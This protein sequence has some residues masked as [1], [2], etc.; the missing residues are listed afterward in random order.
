MEK[1]ALEEHVAEW[2]NRAGDGLDDLP[3]EKGRVVLRLLLDGGDHR[4]GEQGQ[5][6]AGSPRG[7]VVSIGSPVSVCRSPN[8]ACCQRPCA[9]RVLPPP[10][11]RRPLSQPRSPSP[12]V[13][14]AWAA[15]LSGGL[16]PVPSHSSSVSSRDQFPLRCPRRDSPPPIPAPSA[17]RDTSFHC[18]AH[19]GIP[20]AGPIQRWIVPSRLPSLPLTVPPDA[21]LVCSFMSPMSPHRSSAPLTAAHLSAIVSSVRYLTCSRS[22]PP[23]KPPLDKRRR[24]LFCL[25]TQRCTAR[26]ACDALLRD[27][28]A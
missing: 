11:S 5:S 17:G 28:S 15:L 21:I 22:C 7:R 18:D 24:P 13:A 2:A 23:L 10:P 3:Q 25:Y 20:L 19:A 9:L 16:L 8:Y 14:G 12:A 27:Y 1:R 4:R 26:R 6:H